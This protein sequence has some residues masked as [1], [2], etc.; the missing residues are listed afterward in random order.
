[1][2]FL[3]I[4]NIV[5]FKKTFSVFIM[6]ISITFVLGLVIFNSGLS[7]SKSNSLQASEENISLGHEYSSVLCLI[8]I[9]ITAQYLVVSSAVEMFSLRLHVNCFILDFLLKIR[10]S[11]FHTTLYIAA[12]DNVATIALAKGKWVLGKPAYFYMHI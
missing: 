3:R 7:S 2:Y 1:M 11:I 12:I 10:F 8:S 9:Y 6:L 5:K 4:T